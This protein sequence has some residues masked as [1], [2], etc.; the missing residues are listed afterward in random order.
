MTEVILLGMISLILLIE[1][2]V[3]LYFKK[4]RSEA[5]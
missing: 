4:H 1:A 2:S 5:A 3:F